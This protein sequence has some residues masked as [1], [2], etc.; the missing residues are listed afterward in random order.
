MADKDT[1]NTSEHYDLLKFALSVNGKTRANIFGMIGENA[2]TD[3][4]FSRLIGS[5]FLP[6]TDIFNLVVKDF[7]LQHR[8]PIGK[9]KKTMPRLSY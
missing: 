1:M 8:N 3:D 5:L 6:V 4:V 7:L 9:V 2:S